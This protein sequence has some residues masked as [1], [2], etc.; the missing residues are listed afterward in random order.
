MHTSAKKKQYFCPSKRRPS[1]TAPP[2]FYYWSH[3]PSP[4]HGGVG[5]VLGV[6]ISAWNLELKLGQSIAWV[7]HSLLYKI[8]KVRYSTTKTQPQHTTTNMSRC[9]PTLWRLWPSISMAT[10]TTAVALDSAAPYRP[11]QGARHRVRRSC[12]LFPCLGAPMQAP[13]NNGER[14]GPWH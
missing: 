3:T 6:S 12:C 4:V 1:L 8:G 10:A 5:P 13:S 7:R 9:R 2:H 14:G 11:M